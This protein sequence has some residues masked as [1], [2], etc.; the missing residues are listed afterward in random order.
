MPDQ[1][2]MVDIGDAEE[3]E[4][5]DEE[6]DVVEGDEAVLAHRL[7]THAKHANG[8]RT[9]RDSTSR[10]R[11]PSTS[12]RV[13]RSGCQAAEPTTF[14]HCQELRELERMFLMWIRR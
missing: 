4:D 12:W 1:G 13:Q 9:R 14:E 10:D 5:A 6:V 8:R 2:I 11:I 7:Q 3:D